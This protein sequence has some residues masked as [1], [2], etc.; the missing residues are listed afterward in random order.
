MDNNQN[1]PE[2][3][4]N[5]DFDFGFTA[6]DEDELN[7]LVQLDDQTTPDEIKEM[8]EK[9]DLILQMN[10]TCDGATAV[11]EQYDVLLKAKMEE[12]EKATLPLLLNLKKN[13]QKDYLF[14]PGGEREAKCDLQVQKIL[15]ITRNV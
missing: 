15:N 6:A 1:I 3:Y 2:E 10:S 5:G 9:L 12:V 14:W 13:K 4:L 11:K 8:Q 7:A